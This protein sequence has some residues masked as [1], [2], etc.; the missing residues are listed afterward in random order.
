MSDSQYTVGIYTLGCKVNQY[1]S[2]AIAERFASNGFA[3]QA[4]TRPCDVYV[5]NT[6][7]VTAE[8]DRKARQFIRRAIHQNPQAYVL[9]TGCL[10]QTQPEQVGAID[11]VDYICGN[12]E[13]QSVVDAAIRLLKSG[14]KNQSPEFSVTQPD[15]LGF[16]QMTITRF[17]RTRAYIKIEDG[18]ENRC[19]Y[20]IIPTARGKVR[21]KAPDE[22][23]DEVRTLTANGCREIV[24][25]GIE[26]ASYGKDL[27]GY[28]LA[29][30]LSE[31]DRI[32]GIGR[33]RL[34]SLDPSLMKQPFVDRIAALHSLAPHFHLSMQSGSD[35]V[36]ALMKRKYNR[37]MALE[38]MQRLREAIPGVQ[39]TTDMIV[40][41][42]TESD[43]DFVDTLDLLRQ[44]RFL[45]VHAFPYSRRAGTPAA[46]LDG[47]IPEAV[48]H[49]RMTS[50]TQLQTEI[51]RDIL[52]GMI[53]RKTEVLFETH[54]NDL[55][56][57][58]AADFT[59]VCV[60]SVRPLHA[61]ILPV[62][63]EKND[64]ER[65]FGTLCPANTQ[66]SNE[67]EQPI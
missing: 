6:C 65:L 61:K 19:T 4:P 25:T 37:G 22:V 54:R 30:L 18:C 24:L 35:R 23:L 14:A 34:G 1:E 15:S 57:G 41:F 2:E 45:T 67:G 66:N 27:E 17:N 52:N 56:Y 38:G 39:F 20:C 55:A 26:T 28:G 50:L 32:P 64:G 59:E 48:K 11:G 13:K 31:I 47:Q 16:E 44:A 7:T 58:H 40:G 8:S 9:V 33:V 62:L 43:E 42:P 5:I 49:E 53:G 60:P 46:E 51:R 36:L 10:S 3:V 21:S 12:A 63:I 29:E